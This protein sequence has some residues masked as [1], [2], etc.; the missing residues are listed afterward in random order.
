MARSSS[1][2]VGDADRVIWLLAHQLVLDHEVGQHADRRPVDLRRPPR[3]VELVGDGLVDLGVGEE[4]RARLVGVL[5][6]I[7][8]RLVH[9]R[10]EPLDH[11]GVVLRVV[12]GGYVPADHQVGRGVHEVPVEHGRALGPGH[13]EER[14]DHPRRIDAVLAKRR[15]HFR[16]PEL[17]ELDLVRIAAGLAHRR[18]HGDAADIIVDLVHRDRLVLEVLQRLHRRVGGD[19]D[20]AEILGLARRE[21]AGGDHLERQA[22]GAGDQ[23][24]DQVRERKLVLPAHHPGDGLGAACVPCTVMSRFCSAKKPLAFPRWSGATSTMAIAAIV[25]LV[26][27]AGVRRGAAAVQRKQHRERAHPTQS[28]PAH[29]SSFASSR[30]RRSVPKP[31]EVQ[32]NSPGKVNSVKRARPAG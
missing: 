7:H 12:R 32:E 22:L 13:R 11:V 27:P 21:V 10:G 26:G 28:M 19:E 1:T 17:D 25:S 30:R 5:G 20:G 18:A 23:Q 9:R 2:T 6:R 16:E 31:H 3:Q 4:D 8:D 14:L 15:R 24:R 29:E